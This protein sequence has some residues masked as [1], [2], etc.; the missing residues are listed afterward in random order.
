[1]IKGNELSKPF[2]FFFFLLLFFRCHFV[3]KDR[4]DC[5]ASRPGVRILAC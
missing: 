5:M 4:Q 2:F 3:E 1:M